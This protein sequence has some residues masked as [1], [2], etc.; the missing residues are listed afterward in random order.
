MHLISA[1]PTCLFKG[2]AVEF[3]TQRGLVVHGTHLATVAENVFAD[4]RGAA[5]R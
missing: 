4:V 3:G 1:C 5:A 2:N